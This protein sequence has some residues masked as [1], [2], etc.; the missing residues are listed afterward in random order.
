MYKGFTE[1]LIGLSQQVL[2]TND[3]TMF[4][5]MENTQSGLRLYLSTEN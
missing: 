2:Y 1:L 5:K 4:G 3:L